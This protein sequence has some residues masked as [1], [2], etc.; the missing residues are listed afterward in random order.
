M[1]TFFRNKSAWTRVGKSLRKLADALMFN[2]ADA[3]MDLFMIRLWSKYKVLA[4]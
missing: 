4:L 1:L 2:T 3:E